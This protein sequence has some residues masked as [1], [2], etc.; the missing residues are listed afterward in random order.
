M[1]AQRCSDAHKI[2]QHALEVLDPEERAQLGVSLKKIAE[3]ICR[4]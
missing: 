4:Y 3:H 2:I 1:K